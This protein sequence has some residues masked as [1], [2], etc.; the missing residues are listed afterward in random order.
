MEYGEGELLDANINRSPTSYLRNPPEERA[1][2]V[3]LFF[4]FVLIFDC[5]QYKYI[6]LVTL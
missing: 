1:K 4:F 3:N 6:N 5:T 2:L